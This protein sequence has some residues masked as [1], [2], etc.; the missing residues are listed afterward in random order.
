MRL[1]AV[2]P[3]VV[4]E[5]CTCAL[6][7]G[8]EMWE[9]N[10]RGAPGTCLPFGADGGVGS[11]VVT[12]A[13]ALTIAGAHGFAFSARPDTGLAFLRLQLDEAGTTCHLSS[14]ANSN[15][16]SALRSVA[17]DLI[18]PADAGWVGTYALGSASDGGRTGRAVLGTGCRPFL[19]L[20]GSCSTPAATLE[21]SIVLEAVSACGIT[22]RFTVVALSADGG[23]GAGESTG[24]FASVYC[25]GFD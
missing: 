20:L 12:G 15:I 8:L 4:L 5:A 24:R 21:G 2:V 11:G 19:G 9:S 6:N 7:P 1:L 13:S 22:G 3:L 25:R 10:D 17:F 18:A 23:S 14:Q 16:A